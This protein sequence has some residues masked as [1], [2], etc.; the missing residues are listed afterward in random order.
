MVHAVQQVHTVHPSFEF[1]KGAP[2]YFVLLTFKDLTSE[3]SYKD[4]PNPTGYQQKMER[5]T[6]G[7]EDRLSEALWLVRLR[8]NAQPRVLRAKACFFTT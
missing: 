7:N 5:T 4:L 8:C 3:A 2:T 6:K 1:K